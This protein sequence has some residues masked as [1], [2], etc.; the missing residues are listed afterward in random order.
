[1]LTLDLCTNC[2]PWE[3]D[4]YLHYH[5]LTVPLYSTCHSLL[6]RIE[7]Y[8]LT[9]H[10]L[11]PPFLSFPCGQCLS[12]LQDAMDHEASIPTL[13][14]TRHL[15]RSASRSRST[16]PLKFFASVDTAKSS[17]TPIS[18]RAWTA[19]YLTDL[20]SNRPARP[21]GSR[22]LPGKDAPSTLV[23]VLETSLRPAS[24]LAF[25]RPSCAIQQPDLTKPKEPER[26]SSAMSYRRTQSSIP[27]T[28]LMKSPGR[29]LARQPEQGVETR[30]FSASTTTT[31]A[32]GISTGGAYLE[33]GQ[34]WMERQEAR[35]LREALED[36]D[37]KDEARLH[38]A[39][40]DEASDL[41][42]QHR[43][44][45]AP[46]RSRDGSRN[47][48]K[49]LEKGSHA[50]SQSVGYAA[51]G[52]SRGAEASSQRSASD[53]SA[54]S[55]SQSA[56]SGRSRN[57][58][59]ASKGG[60]KT[61]QEE[62]HAPVAQGHD[63]WDSPQKK[64]CMNITFPVPPLK[65]LGRRKTSGPR[66]RKPSG[67]LFSNPNDKIYEEPD[68]F[69][70]VLE[71]VALEENLQPVPLK[72]KTRNSV[73]KL[74]SA[75]YGFLRSKTVPEDGLMKPFT[76]EIHKN[77]P[78]QSRNA[79]YMQNESTR[80]PPR[81]QNAHLDDASINNPKTKDGIEIRSDDIRAATS[82]RMKDRS[83][84]L[85]SPTVV[86]DR[87]GRPIVSFDKD[88][89]PR[90]IETA[91]SSTP[92]YSG[93]TS[94]ALRPKPHVPLSTASAPIVPT[95]NIPNP[96]AI[97]IDE[98]PAPPTTAVPV[99]SI[100]VSLEPS[101]SEPSQSTPNISLPREPPPPR[102]L[103]TSRT[104]GRPG[105]F[106]RPLPQHSSTAPV[107]T[108]RPHWSPFRSRPTAQCASCALPI[109]GRIVS[110]AS[111]RFHPQCFNCYHC[112]ELL[113]CVAFYPE[114]S[115][116]RDARLARIE[117]RAQD[118]HAPDFI[119]GHTATDDGDAGLRFYCH[120]DFHELFSPRC[121][122]CKT[123]IEGEVVIAC[124]GEW[125]K[126]HFF[127]AECGDPFDE[128]TP[129]VERNGYAWCVGCHAG[130]FNGKCKG[131]RK[132]ILEQGVQ[133]LG[134]EWHEGCFCCMVSSI[135]W[136]MRRRQ[137]VLTAGCRNAVEVLRMGGFLREGT[138][139][140]QFV[141][142]VKRGG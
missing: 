90:E 70:K 118:P 22:P 16:S 69:M 9:G 5:S 45:G 18:Q 74:S 29:P 136:S 57:S 135:A 10:I 39:A 105:P 30:D 138:R 89:R 73:A 123:P 111:Q 60:S 127:C 82:M 64:A 23:P 84:K 19:S 79:S 132:V 35:S 141:W 47:Y 106:R 37:K 131:C 120:L 8:L 83:S 4:F 21:S 20:R 51:L 72:L 85:P 102:T 41:V 42:W 67:G 6:C 44:Q 92:D 7:V 93:R 121:R 36:M 97:Y 3:Y 38:A 94:A 65:S 24:A 134:G 133:A 128:K 40:Q 43:N 98:A 80:D 88:W 1:M 59:S 124:G 77:P 75:G 46:Y 91:R 26:C 27:T 28:D 122:S 110:A 14:E 101:V 63:V 56:S 78:S 95:I 104:S 25:S 32:S 50:R 129:F 107:N 61:S 115:T 109:A 108:S 103:P 140:S 142:G 53:G 119:D 31:R 96:P 100:E 139:R 114:P 49:H 130:R 113:E 125:H 62:C 15:P 34:R 86:S 81:V 112:S 2:I 68:E 87:P 76:T 99:P 33:R 52:V 71:P 55:K 117:S 11:S 17:N 48:K 54:S 126:G 137:R 58:S 12:M 66:S 13:K 116:S